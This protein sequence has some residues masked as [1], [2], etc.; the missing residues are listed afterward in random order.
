MRYFKHRDG[1]AKGTRYALVDDEGV[2][3]GIQRDGTALRWAQPDHAD[4][5]RHGL[6]MGWW[7]EITK[8]EAE[9]IRLK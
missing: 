1:F 4:L 7:I 2:A 6:D 3:W 8:D 9:A 5:V